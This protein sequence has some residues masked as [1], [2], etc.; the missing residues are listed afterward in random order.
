[1]SPTSWLQCSEMYPVWELQTKRTSVPIASTLGFNV[2]LLVSASAV[3][4]TG[5]S[6]EAAMN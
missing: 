1:M 5:C 6:D 4:T 2:D 3:P